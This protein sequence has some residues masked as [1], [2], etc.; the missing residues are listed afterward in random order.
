M[1]LFS[2]PPLFSDFS[3]YTQPYEACRWLFKLSWAGRFSSR[4]TQLV[5][6]SATER[7]QET[8][9]SHGE[10]SLHLQSCVRMLATA[11][12]FDTFT[13]SKA[14]HQNG[15]YLCVCSQWS[16]FNLHKTRVR[17]YSLTYPPPGSTPVNFTSLCYLLCVDFVVLKYS[18]I[19]HAVYFPR[20]TIFYLRMEWGDILISQL[21]FPGNFR[22]AG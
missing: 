21:S 11:R 9:F 16:S 1:G 5:P 22:V 17:E 15:F 14:R 2:V 10:S 7:R 8:P 19:T 4:G 13:K 3:R 12:C 20:L 6:C 18:L